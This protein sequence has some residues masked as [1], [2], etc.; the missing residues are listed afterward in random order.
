MKPFGFFRLQ[1]ATMNAR[2]V[3]SRIS[4]HHHRG[5][6]RILIF[7]H[8]T[9]GNTHERP[10][11]MEEKARVMMVGMKPGEGP[12]AIMPSTFWQRQPRGEDRLMRM[13][14]DLLPEQRVP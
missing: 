14:N 1:R 13:V 8:L 2:A 4:G 12:F 5:E 6:L 10:E 7:P 11:G 3:F 9:L